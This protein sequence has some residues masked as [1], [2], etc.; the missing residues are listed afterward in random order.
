MFTKRELIIY[1]SWLVLL[2]WTCYA[3]TQ[4]AEVDEIK[5]GA[6]T[7]TSAGN[8]TAEGGNVTMMNLS[9]TQSTTR[10]QGYYGNVSGSLSL[11][12]GSS[13]FFDFSSSAISSVFASQNQTFDFPSLEAG[14]AVDI[15]N[16]WGYSSGADQATDI[17]TGTTS[18]EGVSAPSV[19]LEPSGSNF[20]ST[21]LDDGN[22]QTKSGFAFGVDVQEP[23]APC[24]DGT[25]CEY[26][27]MVPAFGTEVYYFF[28]TIS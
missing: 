7:E 8:D 9:T 22:N 10:W 19:E 21:I 1:V 26:E 18:I 6:L 16:L 4:G 28:L 17:Y 23:A 25:N 5:T 15:D 27:L 12:F 11:G 14:E 3:A 20:N 24:F 2:S 13:I